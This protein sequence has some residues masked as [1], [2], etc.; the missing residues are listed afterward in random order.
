[1]SLLAFVLA[2][3]ASSASERLVTM[4]AGTYDNAAQVAVQPPE[5]SR[6]P[7]P[8]TPWLAPLTARMS[9]IAA[10][11]L[12]GRVVYLQW[13]NADGTLDRQRLWTFADRPDGTVE[14]RFFSFKAPEKFVGLDTK[15]ELAAALTLDDLVAYPPGCEGLFGED[16]MGFAGGIDP[17]R[18]TIVTQRTGR[19]MAI[20]ARI[21]ITP[22]G[23][24]YREAGILEGGAD[25][26]RVPGV[27]HIAFVRKDE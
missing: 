4:L 16:E 23:F 20:E 13:T 7:K 14:M 2:V 26:F 5:V 21:E 24:T 3:S 1:M 22:E 25:A 19:T 15:P 12:P 27:D 8:G 10:P 11:A 9:A 18:C 6:A 17:A